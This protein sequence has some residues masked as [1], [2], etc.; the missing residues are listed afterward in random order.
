MIDVKSIRYKVVNELDRTIWFG[1]IM[2]GD[3]IEENFASGLVARLSISQPPD[4][5]GRACGEMINEVLFDDT[6]SKRDTM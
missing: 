4:N 2:S 6:F 3:Y 5:A 1:T